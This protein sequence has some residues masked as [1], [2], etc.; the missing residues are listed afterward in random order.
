[1]GLARLK[2][3]DKRRASRMAVSLASRLRWS[4]RESVLVEVEDLSIYGLRASGRISLRRGDWVSIEVPELG[5]VTA[6]IAWTKNDRFGAVFRDRIDIPAHSEARR[7][8]FEIVTGLPI[9]LRNSVWSSGPRHPVQEMRLERITRTSET[10]QERVDRIARTT[11]EVHD[12][13]R[14]RKEE[15][16]KRL[17]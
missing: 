12:Y 4:A 2:Q 1:M 17:G 7:G 15:R 11:R 5:P 8:L 13:L 16:A 3:G 14:E 6:R 10:D 9:R